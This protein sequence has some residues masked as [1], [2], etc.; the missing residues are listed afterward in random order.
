MLNLALVLLTSTDPGRRDA[1]QGI[2][3]KLI[4]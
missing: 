2:L 3:G 1:E 4:L